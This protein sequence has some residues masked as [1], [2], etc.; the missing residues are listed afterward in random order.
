M[1][2]EDGENGGR[3]VSR[4]DEGSLDVDRPLK[5]FEPDGNHQYLHYEGEPRSLTARFA[6]PVLVGLGAVAVTGKISYEVL[7][8]G[9][10]FVDGH[11]DLPLLSSA[12]FGYGLPFFAAAG[13]AACG[14]WAT[15]AAAKRWG[16]KY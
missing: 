13:C 4:I 11:P 15:F 16:H 7:N 1:G 12:M 2:E 6:G 5:A 3:L 10:D 14:I 8:W 9:Q